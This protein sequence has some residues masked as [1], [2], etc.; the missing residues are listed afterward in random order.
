MLD[1]PLT[2]QSFS[3]GF[4][5]ELKNTSFYQ[6][7]NYLWICPMKE[8]YIK[9]PTTHA[10]D[11]QRDFLFHGI[12][13]HQVEGKPYWSTNSPIRNPAGIELG[14]RFDEALEAFPELKAVLSAWQVWEADVN[15]EQM[16]L[17]THYLLLHRLHYQQIKAIGSVH[18]PDARFVFLRSTKRT[19]RFVIFGQIQIET[20]LSPVI[21]QRTIHGTPLMD[22]YDPGIGGIVSKW[23]QYMPEIS[24]QLNSIIHSDY[25]D[26]NPANFIFVKDVQQLYYIDSK[27]TTFSSRAVNQHNLDG[28]RKFFLIY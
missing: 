9:K 27:P 25:F 4:C 5:Y 13:S 11:Y 15:E 8:I 2:V 12:N 21:I 22:M 14:S 20:E 6:T 7:N 19:R 17:F 26:W 1:E 3:D 10:L 24:K 23:Q 18:I 28:I 16:R